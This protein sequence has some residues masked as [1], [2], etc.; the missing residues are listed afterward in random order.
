MLISSKTSLGKEK[1][2]YGT[3]ILDERLLTA[4]KE[5]APLYVDGA[6]LTKNKQN[7]KDDTF[8]NYFTKTPYWRPLV[9]NAEIVD[10]TTNPSF[11]NPRAPSVAEN[12]ADFCL[13]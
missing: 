3:K 7:K 8:M 6:G 1:P 4:L 12:E 11:K 9:P 13:V 2:L 5:K 10:K